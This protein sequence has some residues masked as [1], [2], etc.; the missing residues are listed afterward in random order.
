MQSDLGISWFGLWVRRGLRA[1]SY[2]PVPIGARAIDW[3]SNAPPHPIS[4][5]ARAIITTRRHSLSG[6]TV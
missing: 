5:V 2:K 6:F 1:I 3:G 4:M